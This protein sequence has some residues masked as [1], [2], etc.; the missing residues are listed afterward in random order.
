MAQMIRQQPQPQ[1][2]QINVGIEAKIAELGLEVGIAQVGDTYRLSWR[3]AARS[4][5]AS[6]I[7]IGIDGPY[8]ES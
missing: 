3:K 8:P 5:A 6:A 2:I 4:H 7:E 1:Q